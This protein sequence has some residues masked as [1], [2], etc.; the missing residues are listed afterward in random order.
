MCQNYVRVFGRLGPDKF[1]ACGTN[2]HKPMCKHFLLTVSYFSS[3]CL[4]FVFLDFLL[5][6][7]P[8]AMLRENFVQ[9]TQDPSLF[10]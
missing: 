1:M 8:H 6:F 2:A 5:L 7:F 10:N 9:L 4:N 3:T